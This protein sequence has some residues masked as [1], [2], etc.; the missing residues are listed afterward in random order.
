SHRTGADAIRILGPVGHRHA[1]A[2]WD[3]LH[4]W[5]GGE[6]PTDSYAALAPHL[7]YVQVKDVASAEDTTP[8]PLGAGTLP[9]AECVDV[10][11]RRDW[12]GWLCWEYEKRWYEKATP[13]AELL[14]DGREYLARL[15]GE[16]A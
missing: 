2:L 15:L 11:T 6:Q 10:L 9:L 14:G 12:D 8:L 3:V 16:A 13:L 5:L 7:G 4:T 1:G